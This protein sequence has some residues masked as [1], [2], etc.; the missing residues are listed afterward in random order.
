MHINRIDWTLRKVSYEFLW[1]YVLV[2]IICVEP[3]SLERTK[4]PFLITS[5]D[6]ISQTR[7]FSLSIPF[8]CRKEE[9]EIPSEEPVQYAFLN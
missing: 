8:F 4:N 9:E 3:S 6:S 7:S 1:F 5:I 2:I